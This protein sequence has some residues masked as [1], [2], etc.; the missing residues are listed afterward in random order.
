LIKSLQICFQWVPK[1]NVFRTTF[2]NV[3]SMEAS[4]TWTSPNWQ[5][6]LPLAPLDLSLDF[7]WEEP[8]SS[9]TIPERA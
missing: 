4:W 9:G 1:P 8:L 6:E 5:V 2:R 7:S 3:P